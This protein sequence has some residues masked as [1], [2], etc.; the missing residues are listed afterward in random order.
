M[1]PLSCRYT[2][3]NESTHAASAIDYLL[4]SSTDSTVAFNILDI[5]L[6]LSDHLPIM[7]VC[8]IDLKAEKLCSSMVHDSSV[9][10]AHLRWDHAPL[11]Y[12]YE[13]TRQSLLPV[14]DVLNNLA[15]NSA[16]CDNNAAIVNGIDNV[17]DRVVECLRNSANMFIPKRKKNFYKFWW[18]QELDALKDKAIASCRAWKNAG[19]PRQGF[20]FSEYK[21]DKM[22]Y[23]K[24]IREE[25]ADE[26]SCY[27]NDLHEALLRKKGQDFWKVWKSKFDNKNA[28]SH[29]AQVD[30][31]TDS[32]VIALNFVNYF[33]SNCK[34]FN[35]VRSA[36]LKLQ[37]DTVRAEYC[38]SP[39]TESQQFDVELIGSLISSMKNGKAA[40]LDGLSCEHIKFSHPIVVSILSKLFNLFIKTGHIPASFGASYTVP[41]PK[42]SVK[43]CLSVVDFRGISISPVISKLF[44]M[45]VL[46]RYSDYFK[47]SDHQ[48]GFKKH[49]GCT[50]AI[51]SVRNVIE[52]F[53]SNGSTVNVCT[54]DLSKAF[55]RMNHYALLIKLMDR[56]LPIQLLIIFE[57]W[58]SISITCVKWNGHVS[59]FFNLI[60]G[61]R[62]GGVLSP[63]FFAIFI[64]QLVDRVKSVNAGC[65]LSSVCCS[66]FI[67][68][69]D[70]VLIAPTVSGLQAILAACEKELINIDMCINVSKSKCIRFGLR[71]EAPCADLVSTFGGNIKWVD[72]CRYLGVFFVSGRTFKC[73]FDHAKSRFF[74]AFNA[75]YGRVGRLAS[76][77]VVLGLLRSKCLP[78]LLYATEACPLLSRNKQSLEFTITRI[79]MKIFRTG[80]PVI[81]KECQSNF[82]F[83][84]IQP[85]INIRTARFLQNFTVS[86][87]SLCLLFVTNAAYQL[88]Q[89]I[90][91]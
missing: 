84:P 49:L 65:Y 57:L 87:N 31:V 1:F 29:I 9:D 4:T 6:N 77:E 66:I 35:S 75:V 16:S 72:C 58:F 39:V 22:L 34:P 52:K 64:D 54:L 11:E 46:D 19:K 48:F 59:H 23:K 26:I 10:V 81:V 90:I 27:T 69:D 42:C 7:A 86:E 53:V 5:D 89:I 85:Q 44:E 41:I 71:F 21:K 3:V 70:I 78:I 33:Q 62:Q 43:T 25:K 73:N 32:A 28:I 24:R 80:S 56:K 38:G 74:K 51:Y 36:E 47:T 50:D 13:C 82:N 88:S 15:D 63:L 40:G 45:A 20:L 68:A 83:M 67:Y 76:E 30:G 79:F 55:D 91:N 61:V 18:T 8:Q 14:L 17:Y 2:Y 37:Y 12:Y 60:V